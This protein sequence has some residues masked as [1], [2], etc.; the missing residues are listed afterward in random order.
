MAARVN[1]RSRS[2]GNPAVR[3]T[4]EGRGEVGLTH[5]LDTQDFTK[6][7]LLDLVE[8]IRLL[9]TAAR[10]D[11]VP[12][13]LRDRSLGMIFE[14]PSTRTRVSFE[15]AMTS[16]YRSWMR[17]HVVAT[18]MVSNTKPRCKKVSNPGT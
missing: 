12:K 9:K 13:L 17:S 11:A 6:R 10:A 14:E 1:D 18:S 7:Q 3:E 15:V 8:L 5:F 16:R 4:F 2:A